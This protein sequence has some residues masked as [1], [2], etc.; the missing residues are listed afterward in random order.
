MIIKEQRKK[1]HQEGI[2]KKLQEINES[3]RISSLRELQDTDN[4]RKCILPGLQ[5]RSDQ[6]NS[7]IRQ[8]EEDA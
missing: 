8:E 7:D 3:Y 1:R 2:L 4:K 6:N 5:S